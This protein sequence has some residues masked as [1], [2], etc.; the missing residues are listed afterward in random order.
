MRKLVL[1]LALLGSLFAVS[2]AQ[3]APPASVF[4]GAVACTTQGV[5][6]YEGQTWC[7]SGQYNQNADIRSAVESFDGVP[8]D[9]NVAF[10]DHTQFGDGPYPLVYVF[11]GY[12]GGK[13]NFTG[14]QHWLDKGYAVFSQTNRGFHES[15]GTATSKADDADCVTK[16]FVRLDDTRYEVRDA[17][18]FAGMLVDEDLVQPNKIAATGGSYGGGMSMALAALKDRIMLP[19]G[20]YAAWTSPQG[21]P[22]SIAVAIPDI[23]WTDLAYSLVPNGSNIDYIKDASYYGPFGIMK[24]SYVNGLYI[25]GLGAPGYYTDPGTQPEA[26]L[27]GWKA[28]MDAGEPFEGEPAAEQML[29]EVTTHH[30]SYYIDHSQAPA[31]LLISSGFTDDLFPANEATRF[32]NRTR[33]Q[34]PN[35]PIGL[36]FGSFGHMRGQNG[37]ETVNDRAALQDAWVDYY[38]KG[39]GSQPASNVTTWTQVCPN[40]ATDGGPYVTDNWV[41]QSPGEIVLTDT[42]SKT[43]EPTGGD[44]AAGGTFNPAPSGTACATASGTPETGIANYETAAAPAGGF[45]VMGSPTVIARYS[46]SSDEPPQVAARLVDISADG[47]TK[48]LVNR[49]VWRLPDTGFQVFQLNPNGWHVDEGHKLRLELLPFDGGNADPVAGLLSNFGRPTNNE[50]AITVE[51][52]ELRVPVKEQPGS[53]SGLVKAPAK[54]VLPNRPG[55]ELAP[56]NEDIGSETI[57]QYRERNYPVVGKIKIT[58][59]TVK[60][61]TLTAKVFCA[62]SNDSCARAKVSFKGAPKKGKGKGVVLATKSNVT[63]PAGKTTAVRFNLTAKARALF[64]DTVKRKVTRKNGRKKVKKVKVSGL[65]SLRSQVLIGGKSAGFITVKRTGKVN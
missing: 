11:H 33:A 43:I 26:D 15:C 24:Q 31:P 39:T 13:I 38:L 51:D 8:I 6:D 45:T 52:L 9:V 29:T 5:G 42:G 12:G 62:G 63:G 25:S 60:G 10:P 18:L 54:R 28:F 48:T 57:E 49:G 59:A 21:T 3:A 16:G 56:G 7:G 1:L 40:G 46:Y 22:M 47:T 37:S 41:D 20:T 61:K 4:N 14:M 55:V 44:R 23:P 32:Y 35:S 36:F 65:K 58:G 50:P 34:Y 2:A 53:L 17:Q 30:S 19:D 27:A 64:K